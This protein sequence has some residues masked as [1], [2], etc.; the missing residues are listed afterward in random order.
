MSRPACC[1][2]AFRSLY[3]LVVAEGRI[4]KDCTWLSAVAISSAKASRRKSMSLSEPA[5]CNGSTAI[6]VGLAE[7]TG[8][9]EG[10]LACQKIRP[11]TSAATTLAAAA[12]IHR[13]RLF[14]AT[15]ADSVT[16]DNLRDS[17]SRFRRC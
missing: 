15:G 11:N 17:E 9:T 12:A 16:A 10:C 5:Y 2:S 6:A 14:R 7:A 3:L 1:K 13:S 4:E 8:R